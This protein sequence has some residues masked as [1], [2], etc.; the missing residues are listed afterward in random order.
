M[1][2]RDKHSLHST[3]R[4]NI[5]EHLFIG[6]ILR[7]LWE[8]GIVDAEVLKS[9][10]DAGGYDLVLT[11]QTVTR[12]IQLKVG[13]V[14]GSR[15]EVSVNLRLAEKPSGCVI[16][17]LVDDDLHRKHFR[18]FGHPPGQPLPEVSTMPVA[19]HAKGTGI[20]IKNE[21]PN[22]R[23][24]KRTSFKQV[25]DLDGLLFELSGTDILRPDANLTY[26]SAARSQDFL[27]DANGMPL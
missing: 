12:H 8:W 21:R 7:R 13:R 20:G 10:F 24:V 6:E 5:V 25:D 14:T 26:V 9:E 3:L 17:I 18:W 15:D 2:A 11:C 19:R 22:H 27:Y 1:D 4:E 16:W 23:I